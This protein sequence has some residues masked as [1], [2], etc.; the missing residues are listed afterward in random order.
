MRENPRR[1][2]KKT[3]KTLSK[4]MRMRTCVVIGITLLC[5]VLLSGQ[6]FRIQVLQQDSWQQKAV[7]QQLADVELS[8]NRGQIYDANMS[9]LALTREVYTVVMAPN[10][11]RQETTR[12]KIADQV[13]VMLE[14]DREKLYQQTTDSKSKY[15]VVKEKIDKSLADTFIAWVNEN[16]LGG[17]FRVIADYK[18]E[19]PLKNLLSCVLGFVGKDNVAREGLELKYNE[20]LSGTAG[21][22]VSAQNT[23]GDR[24]PTALQYEYTVD[25]TNGNSL[26]LTVDQYIQQI[27]DK[28]LQEAIVD[29]KVTNRT[30][31]IVMD[32]KT[33]A[34]LAM[35]T[36][37]D[38]D[39]N[40]YQAIAD[41][42]IAEK[43]A[44]LSGDE[45]SKALAKARTEQYRN[46]ALDFYEPGSVFKTFTASMGL[47]EGLV[48][49][50]SSFYCGNSFHIADRTMKCWIYPK[51]HGQQN[52]MQAIANSCNPS[53]MTLGTR[54]GAKLFSKYYVGFGFTEKTG[55]DLLGEPAVTSG[56]Y[57]TPQTMSPVDTAASSIGQTFKV[58]PL[59]MVTAL[60]AVANGGYLME[61]YIVQKVLD[62]N[63]NVVSNTEPKVKRQMISESTSKRVCNMLENAVSGGSIKNAY[64]PGYRV[65]GKT[66]T[67]EKT[68]TKSEDG[69]TTD[70]E[71]IVSFGG[72]APAD[73]P[74]VA[75]LVTVDEPQVGKSGGSV[76]APTAKKILKDVLPY[77][78]VEPNY[79]EKELASLDRHVPNVVGSTTAAAATTLKASSLTYHTVGNGKTVVQQVPE[80]GSTIPRGGAVWLYTDEKDVQMTTIPDFSGRTVSQVNQAA[81]TAGVNVLLSGISA[82]ATGRATAVRQSA[83]P[84]RKVPKGTVVNV[85]FTYTDS[86]Y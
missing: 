16:R 39:P 58:T 81:T 83:T 74:R 21:R 8:A 77:L 54:I 71:I 53:F 9:V 51:G 62:E 12:Q 35:S 3:E 49:E 41:P 46:K 18:R 4:P 30:C 38:Y 28:C 79:T 40:N 31:A 68:E 26:V 50:E 82:S 78:G 61:P 65:A 45:H 66:G 24:L 80:S 27:A 57:H 47:E 10:N 19:Y 25:A 60:S 72:F 75:V 67:S 52:F 23:Y 22:M 13:S 43:L 15:K 29:Y 2:A 86:I 36:K 32:V 76:A 1:S 84:G 69:D 59:Q 42:S 64:L 14:V 48:T 56:L 37:N 17:V 7:A 11:I 34:I 73:D 63:G 20:T 5:F 33:G 55:V 44:L 85:E 70:V 6:L